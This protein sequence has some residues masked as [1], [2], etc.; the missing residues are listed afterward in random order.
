MVTR[1]WQGIAIFDM[2]TVPSATYCMAIS[3]NTGI[4]N[5]SLDAST[6]PADHLERLRKWTKTTTAPE[7]AVSSVVRR[8]GCT[9]AYGGMGRD[10]RRS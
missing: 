2:R 9:A 7:V 10:R 8:P 4:Q 1:L 6:Q 3:R 5:E